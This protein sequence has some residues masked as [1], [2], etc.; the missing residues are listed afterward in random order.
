MF[1]RLYIYG[2]CCHEALFER[3]RPI[4]LPVESRVVREVSPSAAHVDASSEG[5]SHLA[6]RMQCSKWAVIAS[7][8][9]DMNF[10]TVV[11][12]LHA[13]Y[14]QSW[15]YAAHKSCKYRLTS[16]EVVHC[17]SAQSVSMH[18]PRAHVHVPVPYLPVLPL[19]GVRHG[20]PIKRGY[21][22]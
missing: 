22:P 14:S 3:C 18:D 8:C 17:L 15:E 7:A 9:T 13:S 6:G 10:A 12:R 2:R 20:M 4:H 11:Q 19:L 5:A 1:L 21:S 16:Y